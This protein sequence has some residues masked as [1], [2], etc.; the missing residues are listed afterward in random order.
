MLAKSIALSWK[1]QDVFVVHTGNDFRKPW[2]T[3]VGTRY[4]ETAFDL[5]KRG[6]TPPTSCCDLIEAS[7]TITGFGNEALR[8][9]RRVMGHRRGVAGWN[10]AWGVVE[11]AEG[12]WNEGGLP[13]TIKINFR[14][15]FKTQK[16]KSSMS[17]SI[18]ENSEKLV[19][20]FGRECRKSSP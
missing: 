7:I 6:T 5:G 20:V 3:A 8:S 12:G 15:R 18:P 14:A 16:R 10:P 11:N 9:S 2:P 1:C 4:G 19:L 13:P 17:R